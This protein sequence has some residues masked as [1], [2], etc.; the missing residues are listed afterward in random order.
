MTKLLSRISALTF[1]MVCL[2]MICRAQ[3]EMNISNIVYLATW[4]EKGDQS[5]QFKEPLSI[6]VDP[7]GFVYVADTGNNRVQK[8][9]STGE[10]ITEIG[11]YGW[12]AEQF[13]SPVAVSSKN[14][15]D[16]FVA[17]YY[18]ERIER[19]D[20]DLHYLATLRSSED[21]AEHLRFGFPID[22]DISTQG[23]L[24][25]LDGENKRLLKLDVL[26][27]PQISFGG[28]DAG[29]GRLVE[30]VRFMMGGN[31]IF[32]SDRD[33]PG[34]V[35][36]DL[37]GNF[38]FSFGNTVLKNPSGITQVKNENLLVTDIDCHKIYVFQ[39][40]GILIGSFGTGS[41]EPVD[42]ACWKNRVYVLDKERCVIDIY[43][44][45]GQ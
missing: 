6:D 23:E 27:D 32:V 8:I 44:W 5:L 14:G 40:N 16:V 38:L 18:N 21:I 12:E 39:E 34:I 11:G 43:Q 31:R 19:Y 35:V 25:C 29:E 15:L 17:D 42:V 22:T 2:A 30:P 26:G 10:F 20:K 13:D 37:Y 41:I 33:R 45:I 9:S 1:F 36:F 28:F 4:G 24:F 7:A 3:E